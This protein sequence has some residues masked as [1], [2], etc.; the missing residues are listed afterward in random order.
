MA[1]LGITH[2][3]PPVL[4]QMTQEQVAQLLALL[5]QRMIHHLITAQQLVQPL[6]RKQVILPRKQVILHLKMDQLL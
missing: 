5:H 1:R 3:Q 4:V 6:P 2:P